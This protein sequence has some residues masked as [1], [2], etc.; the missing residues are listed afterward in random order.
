M[1]ETD[2]REKELKALA[3]RLGV[4]ISDFPLLDRAL[5]H[6]SYAAEVDHPLPDYESLE[7]LGDAVLGLAVGHHLFEAFPNRTPGEYSKMRAGLVNRRSVARAAGELGIARAIRLG[8]GEELSGGRQR[9]SLIADCLEALIAAVYLDCGWD[10]ARAFVARVFA[11]ELA[12]AHELDRV[13]D[14]KS[15][16]QDFCQA[17]HY[18]LPHFEVVRS[19]GPDHKKEFEVEVSI[20]KQ[21]L[22]RGRGPTKKEAAQ[23]AARAALESIAAQNG[24]QD[25]CPPV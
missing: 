22:G 19:E 7:F 14:F 20:G 17:R 24:S 1:S 15:R 9:I 11:H 16:L 6:A 25:T 2:D 5:T 21:P 3:A 18:P 8:K 4:E 10:I 13:W 12:R 23:F